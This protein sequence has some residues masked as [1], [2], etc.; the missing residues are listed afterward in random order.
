MKWVRMN[1]REAGCSLGKNDGRVA[2]EPAEHLCWEIFLPDNTL[3][4]CCLMM[5]AGIRWRIFRTAP[6][7]AQGERL[8]AGTPFP[9]AES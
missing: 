6:G 8:F 4:T 1:Q 3:G 5:V 9:T 7:G 2:L